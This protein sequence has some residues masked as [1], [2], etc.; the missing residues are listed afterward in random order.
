MFHRGLLAV[1]CGPSGVGKGTILKLVKERDEKLR[2]SVSVTTRKPRDGEIE[3]QNYFYISVDEFKEMI[4]NDEL[5]EWV[6]Y[7]GNYYGTP[8]K[9]IEDSIKDGYNIILELEVEG[10][11]NIKN[12]YPDSLSVFIVPPSYIDLKRR[13]EGRGTE[14]IEVI[15]KRLDRA[16]EEVK[17]INKFDYVIVNDNIENTA[18]NLNNILSVEKFKFKR[19]NNIL[20]EIGFL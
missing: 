6:E 15:K 20:S 10:A 18:N 11:A 4:K 13:I 7:C 16:K 5:I 9:Y 14:N 8:K 1:V 17:F 12:K 19:N 2:F 3:G